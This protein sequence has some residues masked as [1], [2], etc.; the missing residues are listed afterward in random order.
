[1]EVQKPRGSVNFLILINPKVRYRL[2]LN[3][4]LKLFV[5]GLPKRDD[6]A[7]GFEAPTDS[8]YIYE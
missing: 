3:Q 7:R 2:Y 8:N 6:A 5:T 1:M 4:S